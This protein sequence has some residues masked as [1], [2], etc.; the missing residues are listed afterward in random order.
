[1]L[2]K[3]AMLSIISPVFITVIAFVRTEVF[4][5][6]ARLLID[7]LLER[8]RA[9]SIKN[10]GNLCYSCR[11]AI[12]FMSPAKPYAAA[13]VHLIAESVQIYKNFQIAKCPSS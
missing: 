2:S 6:V 10:A 13:A 8:F 3:I 7:R 9:V 5:S 4:P 11:V 12:R 1:M